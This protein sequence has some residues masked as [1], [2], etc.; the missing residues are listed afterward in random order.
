ME[1]FFMQSDILLGSVCAN[2]W[3]Q[4]P[5][6]SNFAFLMPRIKQKLGFPSSLCFGPLQ[7]LTGE[8][9]TRSFTLGSQF[10]NFLQK[11]KNNNLGK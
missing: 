10:H 11:E 2:C 5:R 4:P 7:F 9:L 8:L 1:C 6:I 3:S